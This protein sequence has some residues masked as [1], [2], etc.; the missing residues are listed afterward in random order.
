MK[1]GVFGRR[2]A[3]SGASSFSLLAAGT[4]LLFQSTRS[5]E[6]ATA[7][8]QQSVDQATCFNPCVHCVTGACLGSD[9]VQRIETQRN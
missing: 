8:F 1:R 6:G 9:S 4:S 5:Y 2:G 7:V 3:P